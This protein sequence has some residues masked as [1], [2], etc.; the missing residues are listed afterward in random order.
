MLCANTIVIG[1]WARRMQGQRASLLRFAVAIGH[2]S[3]GSQ[4]VLGHCSSS[5][6]VLEGS[7]TGHGDLGLGD[8]ET[9]LAQ[10]Q[11]VCTRR[12]LGEL[13][14]HSTHCVAVPH[15]LAVSL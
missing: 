4:L 3:L 15:G 6:K 7:A 2:T 14:P 11:V 1:M 13:P 5:A 10:Q 9:S 12:D 8:D